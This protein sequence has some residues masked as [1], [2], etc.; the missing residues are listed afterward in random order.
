M[1]QRIQT[2]YMLGS[3]IAILMMLLLPLGTITS[4][5]ATFSL[6]SLGVTSVT[7]TFP[8]DEMR[9][10]LLLLLLL[11][12]ALPL[13]CIFLYNNRKLQ[14]RIL[15]YTAILDV[16]FYG[17]FFF[18]EASA[19]LDLVETALRTAGFECVPE[20]GYRFVVFAMP[21][22]SIFGC[23]MAIRGVAYDIALLS[24]ADR[25]RPSRK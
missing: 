23:V 19:S 2:I 14:M 6:S 4:P 20:I 15:I 21:A 24:S 9:Y 1:L 16:L 10:P 13:V 18:F 11:M 25:L 7:E 8:L 12:F 3:V 22:V 5:E 17:Y